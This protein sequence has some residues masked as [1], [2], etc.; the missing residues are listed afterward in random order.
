M[1]RGCHEGGRLRAGGRGTALRDLHAFA[2]LPRLGGE[3]AKLGPCWSGAIMAGLG[4]STGA[5]LRCTAPP[6]GGCGACLVTRTSSADQPTSR[7][8]AATMPGESAAGQGCSLLLSLP[9]AQ[10]AATI[11]A[12]QRLLA[13]TGAGLH[14]ESLLAGEAED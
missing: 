10:P 7:E 8:W 13:C 11:M 14:F 4:S 6:A 2:A 9:P 1:H 5:A 12:V 3:S